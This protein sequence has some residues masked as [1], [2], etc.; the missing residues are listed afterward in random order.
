MTLI[1]TRF[2][3]RQ[4]SFSFPL[5]HFVKEE[6]VCLQGNKRDLGL[7]EKHLCYLRCYKLC[8]CS[9]VSGGF[10]NLLL[11]FLGG[12]KHPISV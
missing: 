11:G 6:Q 5:Q 10:M 9:A 8:D 7:K 12:V 4:R 3:K 1:N 2:G